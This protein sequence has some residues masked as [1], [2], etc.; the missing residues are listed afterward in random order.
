MY[1][2]HV[3][4]TC[5]TQTYKER[6]THAYHP[7]ASTYVSPSRSGPLAPLHSPA[8]SLEG[9]VPVSWLSRNHT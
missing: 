4:Y 9:M 2:V 5:Y 6:C 1:P 8:A 7:C 3:P